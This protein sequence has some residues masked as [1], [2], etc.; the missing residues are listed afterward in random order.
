MVVFKHLVLLV[1]CSLSG[2]DLP[3]QAAAADQLYLEEQAAEYERSVAPAEPRRKKLRTPAAAPLTMAV[4]TRCLMLRVHAL[5]CC[6]QD[7]L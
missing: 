1:M 6:S 5:P 7:H 2:I 3:P 4:S